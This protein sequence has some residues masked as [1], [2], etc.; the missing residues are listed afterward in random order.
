MLQLFKQ[1]SEADVSRRG[2]VVWL[3]AMVSQVKCFSGALEP[4][5]R[6]EQK[7]G[8]AADSIVSAY[9]GQMFK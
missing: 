8:Q 5:D 9:L 2:L 6:E 7:E 3:W 4:Q 1:A